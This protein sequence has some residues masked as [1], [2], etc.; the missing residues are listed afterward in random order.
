MEPVE[1]VGD[2][3]VI[4][5]KRSVR[6]EKTAARR[7][8]PAE[9]R[10]AANA[11]IVRRIRAVLSSIPGSRS[12]VGYLSDG[13]EPDPAPVL[14]DALKSGKTLCLP[15]FKDAEHYD[16]AVTRSLDLS[17]EKYGIPEPPA[18]APEAADSDLDDAVWL[19]PGVAFDDA[20]RRLGR[21]KGVYDR[22]LSNRRPK[23]TIGIF[24]ECQRCETVPVSPHDRRLDLVITEKRVIKRADLAL[25]FQ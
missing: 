10:A 21:G 16:L 20:C 4:G 8:L 12:L 7:A 11:A 3:V 1:P 18:T 13:T 22:L 25:S 23:L 9:I 6:K 19:V 17:D 2:S 15:R 5:L 24:Y 14:R